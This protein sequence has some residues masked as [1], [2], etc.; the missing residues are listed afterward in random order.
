MKNKCKSCFNYKVKVRTFHLKGSKHAI[1]RQI[2][3]S[4]NTIGKWTLQKVEGDVTIG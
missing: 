4:N 1:P 3:K 2:S